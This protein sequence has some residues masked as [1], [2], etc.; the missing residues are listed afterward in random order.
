MKAYQVFKG[1]T[2]KQGR[3]YYELLAMYFDKDRALHHCRRL[4]EEEAKRNA[5]VEEHPSRDGK[6]IAWCAV[7]RESVG[8]AKFTEIEIIE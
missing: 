6:S 1:D 4:A 3:Q 2:D 8:I 5:L 7:V